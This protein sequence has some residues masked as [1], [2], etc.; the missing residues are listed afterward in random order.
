M[1]KQVSLPKISSIL[2]KINIGP[3]CYIRP[4]NTKAFNSITFRLSLLAPDYFEY[5]AATKRLLDKNP[6]L[7]CI[8]AWN[9]NGME[10]MV[11]RNDFFYR[12]YP[13]PGLGWMIRK[14]L[15]DEFKRNR[16]LGFWNDWVRE[17]P[18]QRKGWS[19][20]RPE[21]LLAT[22]DR[23]YM[24]RDLFKGSIRAAN[25]QKQA[26]R[27]EPEH[28]DKTFVERVDPFRFVF[29]FVFF[30]LIYHIFIS[31]QAYIRAQNNF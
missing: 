1:S 9:D 29:S 10:G 6:T 17:A 30:I 8:S 14:S 7:W 27:G 18:W 15:W 11:K 2:Q 3:K 23:E 22:F 20:I 26:T 25:F 19:C 12:T 31:I 21:I 4:F 24:S 28:N 16:L 13:L 5:F